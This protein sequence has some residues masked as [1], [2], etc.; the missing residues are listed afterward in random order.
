MSDQPLTFLCLASYFKGNRLFERLKAEGCRVF[1]LTVEA[2]LHESWA[3]SSLDDVFAVKSFTD[4]AALIKA[5]AYLFRTHRFDR[6][7][8]LDDFDVEVGA[9]LREHFRRTDSGLGETQARFFRD[10]LAMRG[11]AR[12]LGIRIPDFAPL[13]DHAEI[14]EF[15]ERCPGPWLIKPRSEASAAGIRRCAT[16]DEV[17]KAVAELGDEQSTHLIEQ[18]VP[19]ELFHVDSLVL[20]GKVIF[21]EANAYLRP[22][23]DVYQGG[24]VY[25]TCTLQRELPDVLELRRVNAQVLEGFGLGQGA[26][27]T[28]FMK[29]HA[30]GEFYFIETSARVGGAGISDM[31]EAAAGINLWSEWAK[32]EICRTHGEYELPPLKERYGGVVISLAPQLHPDTSGFTE[33]E[34]IVRMEI[35][36]HI[37]FV[38]AS[39]SHERIRTLMDE[40]MI[41]IARD[42]HAVLPAA[43][44]AGY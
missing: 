1:L 30:D 27:H 18:M 32:L 31:I 21:A 15:L 10:K 28:E 13:F 41:R 36:H 4:R 11:K 29:S 3:R 39:D 6:I 5:V 35:D 17:W 37:G 25:A 19:G 23:L 44:T 14:R 16:S 26:S 38:L 12:E 22:L 43:S 9:F 42:F 2:V 20:E 33:P 40:Y 24:G 7:V 34:I 8:A